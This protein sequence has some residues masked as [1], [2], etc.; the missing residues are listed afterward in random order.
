MKDF[1]CWHHYHFYIPLFLN[2]KASHN[3]QIANLSPLQLKQF[4]PIFKRTQF[5]I[6]NMVGYHFFFFQNKKNP[7]TETIASPII[8]QKAWG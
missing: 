1:L 7:K 5:N 3:Y 6:P 2:L 4:P 8:I